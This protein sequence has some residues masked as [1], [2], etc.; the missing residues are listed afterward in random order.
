MEERQHPG[1]KDYDHADLG[2]SRM[3]NDYEKVVKLVEWFK[4]TDLLNTDA[5]KLVSFVTGEVSTDGRVN[6]HMASDIGKEMQLALDGGTFVSKVSRKSKCDN[7]TV[8]QK[9]LKVNQKAVHLAPYELFHR[10]TVAAETANR[11]GQPVVGIN[12]SAH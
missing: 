12:H 7:F 3:K 5:E 10:L 11:K 6:C 8:L 9:K 2:N 1:A 4:T